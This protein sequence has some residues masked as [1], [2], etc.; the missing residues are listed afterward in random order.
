MP[1]VE[2]TCLISGKQSNAESARDQQC[3]L[4]GKS[5]HIKLDFVI[6]VILT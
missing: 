1:L 2:Q 4:Y 6:V 5:L 3:L